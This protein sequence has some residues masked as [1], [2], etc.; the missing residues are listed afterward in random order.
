MVVRRR[1]AGGDGA[2]SHGG[3]SQAGSWAS[4][5][6]EAP[7]AIGEVRVALESVRTTIFG[8]ALVAIKDTSRSRRWQVFDL[9]V[10]V[11]FVLLMPMCMM[12]W[13]LPG[14]NGNPVPWGGPYTELGHFLHDWFR[15]DGVWWTWERF[16][17]LYGFV[18]AVIWIAAMNAAYVGYA[19]SMHSFK[20]KFP[21]R[22][23][24]VFGHLFPNAVYIPFLV[25]LLEVYDCR[26]PGLGRTPHYSFPEVTCW[27]AY[28]VMMCAVTG[29]TA[30]AFLLL[31]NPYS[32]GVWFNR[33]QSRSEL[34]NLTA[35][36]AVQVVL[37]YTDF[38]QT[39][40]GALSVA[41]VA[42]ALWS[43]L[44]YYPFFRLWMNQLRCASYAAFLWISIFMFLEGAADKRLRESTTPAA[45]YTLMILGIV[46]AGALGY[47]YCG[48][49]YR[50]YLCT[51]R[52]YGLALDRAWH[53][54]VATRFLEEH[55][56]PRAV[57]IAENIFRR[58]LDMFPYS[59]VVRITYGAFLIHHSTHIEKR[60]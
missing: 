53:V 35:M 57:E 7:G 36:L 13:G 30:F 34:M 56:S 38:N 20:F 49:Y 22:Y 10:Q 45:F 33:G 39:L 43:V 2:S 47:Y 31:T 1:K 32:K 17:I 58:G 52:A 46:P 55:S 48:F 29:V 59:A 25:V 40:T 16:T 28:H 23:L 8:I 4:S 21:L 44:A 27:G 3:G 11:T 12:F 14:V 60:I 50:R 9:V 18:S 6:T 24:R 51:G 19:F 15:F 37:C 54:E 42:A 41:C 5:R 26:S